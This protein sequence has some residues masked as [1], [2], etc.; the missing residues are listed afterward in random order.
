MELVVSIARHGEELPKSGELGASISPRDGNRPPG[1]S[2][3]LGVFMPRRDGR[4]P[5]EGKVGFCK[6]PGL[7][8]ARS[9]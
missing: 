7:H 8:E 1:L 2:P 4:R 9:G 5:S 6:A 3:E